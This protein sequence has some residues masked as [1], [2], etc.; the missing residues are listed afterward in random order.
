MIRSTLVWAL[1]ASALALSSCESATV[2][3]S[4][5]NAKSQS[6][7][8][9]EKDLSPN[10]FEDHSLLKASSA[11]FGLSMDQRAPELVEKELLPIVLQVLDQGGLI[12]RRLNPAE[13]RAKLKANRELLVKSENYLQSLGFVGISD[14]DTSRPMARHLGVES[15]FVLQLDRWPCPDCDYKNLM[16][17]KLRYVDAH[18]GRVIWTAIHEKTLFEHELAQAPAIAKQMTREITESFNL[19]FKRKWHKLRYANLKKS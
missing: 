17:L 10:E 6:V 8:L 7:Y 4:I 16:R 11:F 19:K 5:T 18:N 13:T 3:I 9:E 12:Q 14:Q 2:A 15:F 1:V